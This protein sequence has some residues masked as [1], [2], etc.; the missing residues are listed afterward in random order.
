MEEYSDREQSQ[1]KHFALGRYLETASKI[2]GSYKQFAYIDCCA[3]PWE[4]RSKDFRDTSFGIAVDV[5]K[6]SQDWLRERRKDPKF[7]ALLIEQD[8]SAFAMLEGFAR[9]ATTERMQIQARN[10]DFRDHAAEIIQYI[11]IPPSFAFFFVD[12]TGWTPAEISKLMPF[13]KV[14]PC[15]VLINFMSSFV[16]RFLN[17]ERTDLEEILGSDYR[18]L[19]QLPHEEQEDE[20][21]RR[22]CDLV[23]RKGDFKYVCALPVMRRDQDA[24]HFFLIYGT[25]HEKGVEVFKQVERRTEEQTQV[26]RAQRQQRE[27]PNLDLFSPDVL[28]S[29]ERRYRRLA[30]R[31]KRDAIA[32][33]ELLLSKR[34]EVSYDEVWAEALQHSA[35]YESDLRDWLKQKESQGLIRVIGRKRP[36]EALKRD[37]KHLL[38]RS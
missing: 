5:M 13:L 36:G 26:V 14:R 30:D 21:V 3:G 22:Y 15:E 2:I 11:S 38:R 10:W 12:P 7:R 17:D 18:T 32:A 29:R 6:K 34:Q 19:R 25:R 35:V 20:A 31:C 24:I 37:S 27:R 33:V 23:K 8:R 28:Y 4:S 16:V 9:E 1:I